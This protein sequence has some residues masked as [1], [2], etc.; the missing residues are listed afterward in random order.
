MQYYCPACFAPVE[1]DAVRCPACG[2]DIAAWEQS[3]TFT[4]RLI[5]AL[6]HPNP[7]ARMSAII[8]LGNRGEAGAA[9]PLAECA[10]AYP[11]DVVQGLA[12]VESLRRLPDSPEKAAAR[13]MLRR[14]PS[15]IIRQAAESIGITS[16]ES[17]GG[18]AMRLS[19]LP[20]SF[21]QDIIEGRMSIGEW[22]RIGAEVG[23][24]GIDISVLFLRSLEPAYLA[25]VR[26]SIEE[27]G[28]RLVMVTSYP[29]FTHPDPAERRRQ[30]EQERAY[31]RAA[32]LLGA[33]LIRVTAG[34]AHPGLDEQDGIRWA[35]EGLLACEDAGKEAGVRLVL[36]NH[37]KPGCWQYTDFDQPTHIFLELARGIRGT[38]IGINFDTANP[39]AYGDD[40]LPILEQVIDQVVSIHAA[41]TSTRGAL[42]HVLLGT[43]LVPFA[44]IFAFL[45]RHGFAGW[46]C[47]EENS[48]L[49]VEGVRRAAAFIRAT[50]EA[51]G[52]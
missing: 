6:R 12:V 32:G 17:K 5:H 48:R 18:P 20:V 4:E 52:A 47:M 9:L 33:E 35:L 3:H 34:Q 36:E 40:P 41:D 50:W 10:L 27:A 19:C 14:H 29:D 39:I 30:I 15:R 31:I 11:H 51:A 8:T 13:E 23:L 46:I 28:M 44:D 43:G 25:D 2:V 16:S 49:G 7:E 24:D 1:R 21:F 42:N 22:A 45:K 38:T 37:G 26:R